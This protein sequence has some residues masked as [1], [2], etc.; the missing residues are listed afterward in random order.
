MSTRSMVRAP[1]TLETSIHDQTRV[2]VSARMAAASRSPAICAAPVS[3]DD[4]ANMSAKYTAKSDHSQMYAAMFMP[5]QSQIMV[6]GSSRHAELVFLIVRRLLSDGAVSTAA[7][8]V[9]SDM[10]ELQMPAPLLAAA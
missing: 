10:L 1:A 9:T 3:V 4:H 2:V 8:P 6:T 5:S 7:L